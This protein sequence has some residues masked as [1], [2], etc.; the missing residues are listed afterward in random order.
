MKE[1]FF[2]YRKRNKEALLEHKFLL[3]D[4]IKWKMLDILRNRLTISETHL[5]LAVCSLE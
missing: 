4:V 3:Q 5:S 2:L 1:S